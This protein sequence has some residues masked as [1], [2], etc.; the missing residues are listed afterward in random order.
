MKK[1]IVI[2]LITVAL[3]FGVFYFLKF[4]SNL[5]KNIDQ[6]NKSTQ[7]GCVTKPNSSILYKPGEVVVKIKSDILP[8][9]ITDF[10]NKEK[11]EIRDNPITSIAWVAWSSV[12]PDTSNQSKLQLFSQLSSES[13]VQSVANEDRIIN[14]KQ[15]VFRVFFKKYTPRSQAEEV[16][17]KHPQLVIDDFRFGPDLITAIV[18]V[19]QEEL[20]AAKLRKES[21]VQYA[22]INTC[23]TINNGAQIQPGL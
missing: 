7:S 22:D 3:G 4:K 1:L 2:I 21:F 11:I 19:G 13:V 16:I 15:M 17:K 8:S 14:G 18:P 9:Q 12:N 10:A 5:S 20:Y 6:T 23:A